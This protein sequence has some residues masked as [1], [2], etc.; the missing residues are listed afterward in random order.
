M[1]IVTFDVETDG[2]DFD[3]SHILSWGLKSDKESTYEEIDWGIDIPEE[4]TAING[5]T[6][7]SLAGKE[8]PATSIK[9]LYNLLVSYSREGYAINGF[10]INFDINMLY[11]NVKMVTGSVPGKFKNIVDPFVIDKEFNKYRKGKR[12]LS[13]LSEIYGINVSADN[14]HNAMYD[15]ELTHDLFQVMH[16]QYLKS[17]DAKD[18]YANMKYWYEAQSKSLHE[19]FISKGQESNVVLNW[20]F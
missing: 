20:S 4:I 10:N 3:S 18:L 5:F 7:E 19:Y 17:Y 12:N 8:D 13:T 2:V 6:K 11:G 14:L 1:K 9:K 16:D 15:V